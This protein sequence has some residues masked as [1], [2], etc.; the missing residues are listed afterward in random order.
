MKENLFDPKL[1]VRAQGQIPKKNI[2]SAMLVFDV[3]GF[4]SDMVNSSMI[5]IVN[6]IHKSLW[7]TLEP[8]YYWAETKKHS[9]SNDFILIP[10]GDGYC[11]VLNNIHDDEEILKI[12]VSL[13]RSL[14]SEKIKI[15]MGISKGW[16]V[17][18]IDSND[19]LN[20]FGYGIVLATRVCNAA[21]EGQIL[22]H[23]TLAE[24]F[25][26]KR[27]NATLELIEKPFVAKH[28]LE[29]KCYN[30]FKKNEY[31]TEV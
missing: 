5:S 3:V 28:G 23:A 14:T 31:G 27:P 15:R 22:I 13:H 20:V 12:A 4:S 25:L 26:Q 7:E 11:L 10:T 18:T 1:Y 6:E 21:K 16:N 29:I 19:H 17:I 24:A 30:L 8:D 9:S 2:E